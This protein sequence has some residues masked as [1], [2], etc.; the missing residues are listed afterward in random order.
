[1]CSVEQTE[2][3]GARPQ[4]MI[5]DLDGVITDTASIHARAWKIVF[6]EFLAASSQPGADRPFD[7]VDDYLEYVDGR[8]RLEGIR[9]FLRSRAIDIADGDPADSTDA[10]SIHRIASRKN[11]IFLD[12]VANEG[13]YV[14]P[15]S[16]ALI[17][18]CRRAG[19][20][21][22]CV[23]ASRN[24]R[25]ILCAVDLENAFQS[26]V[27]GIVAAEAGLGSKPAPDMYLH[28]ARNLD[29]E[30]SQAVVFEDAEA[31]VAAARAGRFGL[32]IGVDRAAHAASLTQ[33]GADMV[34]GDLGEID[35]ERLCDEYL[36]N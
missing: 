3:A 29:V 26:I 18:Q 14:F 33:A 24:C 22:G 25:R 21:L 28:C 5:F 34:I 27:D 9:G 15:G 13:A 23:S 10:W 2:S 8:N 30:P 1:M 4:A 16:A 20:R 12:L 35:L 19:I 17:E 36:G 6:D 11:R 7:A 32:V 31:G